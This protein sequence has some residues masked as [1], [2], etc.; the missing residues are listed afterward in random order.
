MLPAAEPWVEVCSDPRVVN[1]PLMTIMVI[2]HGATARYYTGKEAQCQV[3][4]TY[5]PDLNSTV[6]LRENMCCVYVL[7]NLLQRNKSTV[8]GLSNTTFRIWEEVPL[9]TICQLLRSYPI[10]YKH[11]ELLGSNLHRPDLLF[12]CLY[13]VYK[14][15]IYHAC[16][17]VS[18]VASQE[19][20]FESSSGPSVWRRM[21]QVS[22]C[23]SKVPE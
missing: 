5:A 3:G 8:E 11:I 18:G 23:Q 16:R 22:I 6:Q 15:V 20:G 4:P 19:E 2:V 17:L 12:I 10:C 9:D 14:I 1:G 7:L 13:D 21:G